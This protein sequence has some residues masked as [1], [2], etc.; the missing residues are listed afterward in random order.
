MHLSFVTACAF[1]ICVGFLAQERERRVKR[2]HQMTSSRQYFVGGASFFPEY[3]DWG[4]DLFEVG[5]VMDASLAKREQHLHVVMRDVVQNMTNLNDYY[6]IIGGF[7]QRLSLMNCGMRINDLFQIYSYMG[8]QVTSEMNC[9]VAELVGE[10]GGS[11]NS[12]EDL[13]ELKVALRQKFVEVRNHFKK[14]YEQI[15]IREKDT[16]GFLVKNNEVRRDHAELLLKLNNVFYSHVLCGGVAMIQRFHHFRELMQQFTG[17]KIIP[18]GMGKMYSKQGILVI[19]G[20]NLEKLMSVVYGV[21]CD[22][23]LTYSFSLRALLHRM[24]SDELKLLLDPDDSLG[25]LCADDI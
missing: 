7:G 19:P 9:V 2:L 17:E 1:V 13:R 8:V 11:I 22:A 10:N 15:M 4:F 14:Q 3:A 25:L 20:I 24:K 16:F 5:C 12:G 18:K 6:R 21:R 23:M